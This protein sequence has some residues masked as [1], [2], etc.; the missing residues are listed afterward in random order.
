[1]KDENG[2][3][4]IGKSEK[5]RREDPSSQISAF[6]FPLSSFISAPR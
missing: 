1:M 3:L 2:K 5:R 6:I 4:K